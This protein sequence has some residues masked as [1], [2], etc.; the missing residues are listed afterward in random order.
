ME[1]EIQALNS[2]YLGFDCSFAEYVFM[3]ILS[4]SRQLT[5][6]LNKNIKK[7]ARSKK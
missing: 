5:I 3:D 7:I 6:T 1:K 2:I 4:A